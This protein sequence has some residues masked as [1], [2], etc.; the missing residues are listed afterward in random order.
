MQRPALSGFIS[1]PKV[2]L[3]FTVLLTVAY[4]IFA[5]EGFYWL[6]DYIYAKY[7]W[8]LQHGIFDFN[9]PLLPPNP[10]TNRVMIF[11]PIALFYAIFGLN[12]YVATLWPLLCTLGCSVIIYLLF[13]KTN[14]LVA[15][16]GIL[17]LG[18]YYHTL[19][20][21]SYLY[22]DN[23]LMFFGFAA[24]AALYR[25]RYQLNGRLPIIYATLFVV[26]NFLAF[27]AKETIIYYLLF[28]LLLIITDF[29]KKKH[30]VFWLWSFLL[31]GLL[32]GA[33]FAFYQFETGDFLHRLHVIEATNAAYHEGAE[34]KPF[35]NL[36]NRL[37]LAP[38]YFFMGSGIWV[39]L[40][41]AL[42][43]VPRLRLKELFLV[44]SGSDFWLLLALLVMLQFWFG[45]TSFQL[46]NPITLLPRMCM[47]LMPPL[48]LAG[49]FGL[50]RYF[51]GSRKLALIFAVLFGVA[52]MLERGNM[53]VMYVPLACFFAWQWWQM[54]QQKPSNVSFAFLL[55]VAVLSLRP[56]HFMR[57]PSLMGFQEQNEIIQSYLQVRK[58]N[59]LVI[60]D[61]WLS[62]MHDFH[63]EFQP[64]PEI[65]YRAFNDTIPDFQNFKQVY[66]L[67]NRAAL[68]NPDMI[69]MQTVQ[70][71]EIYQRYPER[72]IVAEK[73]QVVLYQ[74]K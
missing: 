62:F 19:F 12:I 72:K 73:K 59:T 51:S 2:V 36:V 55:L 24:T 61:P 6:D 17:L 74:L 18:L 31:G 44:R 53:L 5:H 41:F 33:N 39:P 54:R 66:L 37:T 25:F 7:A 21:A 28:Y 20:L 70:E 58:G 67:V 42:G 52:A 1:S 14:P 30:T 8:Q 47:Q 43:L 9:K 10:L 23:I 32:L 50:E 35:S 3:G 57:K 48:C 38:I 11:A 46:Y 56:L 26:F 4:F 34:P 49:A 15:S 13:R 40:V 22:P 27:L 63:Y 69:K 71:P 68:T 16:A 65:Q 45:S 64:N 60:T 29:F